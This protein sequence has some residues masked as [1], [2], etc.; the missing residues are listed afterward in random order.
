MVKLSETLIRK[1][2]AYLS[3]AGE[4]FGYAPSNSIPDGALPLWCDIT[5]IDCD[6]LYPVYVPYSLFVVK[7]EIS[8]EYDDFYFFIHST[9]YKCKSHLHSAFSYDEIV[10]LFYLSFENHQIFNL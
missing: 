2:S 9:I 8:S 3:Y 10:Y 1:Y 5:R 4:D 6:S 7:S